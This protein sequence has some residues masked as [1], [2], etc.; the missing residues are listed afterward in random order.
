MSGNGGITVD[1]GAGEIEDSDGNTSTFVDVVRI[2]G[3]QY[4]DVF[5]G[6]GDGDDEWVGMAGDDTFN[7]GNGD[8]WDQV[9]YEAEEEI[10]S[11]LQYPMG[12]SQYGI[13][14][15]QS[16]S[17]VDV[18]DLIGQGGLGGA[19]DNDARDDF[20]DL[21]GSVVVDSGKVRDTFNN[22]DTLTGIEEVKGTNR[23]DV[24]LGSDDRNQYLG[25]GGNDWMFG[26]GDQDR[27]EGGVGD[28]HVNGGSG[29][30]EIIGGSGADDIDGGA[31][32]DELVFNRTE[33]RRPA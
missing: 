13:F 9:D 31:G 19:L 12:V 20:L 6:T 5:N 18:A 26:G 14:V 3:S 22:T 24:F 8:G 33:G 28:D 23:A 15:N 25:R 16:G 17:G 7:G 30:D 4:A 29:D 10:G 32:R 21:R 27:L 2:E 11:I 1:A